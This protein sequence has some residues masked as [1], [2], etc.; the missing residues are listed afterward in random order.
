M[1]GAAAKKVRLFPAFWFDNGKL[2]LAQTPDWVTVRAGYYGGWDWFDDGGYFRQPF[3]NR[4]LGGANLWAFTTHLTFQYT[5]AGVHP[6]HRWF[7]LWDPSG[8]GN[9]LEV[10][11]EDVGLSSPLDPNIMDHLVIQ[12]HAYS[13]NAD[14][15]RGVFSDLEF[16]PINTLEEYVRRLGMTEGDVRTFLDGEIFS[17]LK[18]T[19]PCDQGDVGVQYAQWS[20]PESQILFP[21]SIEITEGQTISYPVRLREQPAGPVTVNV[22]YND[23]ATIKW[24]D[25]DEDVYQLQ[26]DQTNWN[27]NQ[28][29]SIAGKYFDAGWGSSSH[30]TAGDY[31]SWIWREGSIGGDYVSFIWKEGSIAGNYFM[32]IWTE[33]KPGRIAHYMTEDPTE[34]AILMVRVMDKKT[35]G[36]GY[37][38]TDINR[39]G[40]TNLLDVA[41]VANNF[42]ESTEQPQEIDPFT[43]ADEFTSADIGTTGGSAEY[44]PVEEVWT[45]TGEGADIWSTSDQFHYLYKQTY[46]VTQ[47]TATVNSLEDTHESAKAGLMLRQTLDPDSVHASIFVTP[48]RGVAFQYRETAGDVTYS[49]DSGPAAHLKAPVSLRLI[50]TCDEVTGYYYAGDRWIELGNMPFVTHCTMCDS[51]VGLAVT[52]HVEGT[53]NTATFNSGWFPSPI[54]KWDKCFPPGVSVWIDGELVQISKVSAGQKV[55]KIDGAG[56]AVRLKQIEK[57]EEHEGTFECYDIVLETGNCITVAVSHLFM[58]E[59]GQWKPVESLRSG[60]KLKSHQGLITIRS[61]TKSP[62]PFTGKVYNLKVKDGEEYFVGKDGVIVRDW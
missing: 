29:V 37:A 35:A 52:S 57:V 17:H 48:E 62:T 15:V 39:D 3:E 9:C 27:Q 49:I 16:I 61:V 54:P 4:P 51:F 13:V 1:Y 56:A 23:P 18:M 32:D 55:G 26:F 36:R 12:N 31:V 58:V 5:D 53:T 6:L 7:F 40:T 22:K 14:K 33:G 10:T 21:E 50:K 2:N 24:A 30:Q 47:L 8:Q 20:M 45:V 42:L 28:I 25:F 59:S 46:C 44:D 60:L 41:H 11:T 19:D 34:T 38:G 43:N